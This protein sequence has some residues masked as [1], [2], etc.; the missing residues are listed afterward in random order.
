[1]TVAAATFAHATEMLS[2]WLAAMDTWWTDLPAP[3]A[4]ELGYFG[5]GYNHW[6]VQTNLKFM[7]AA[8][9]L[10]QQPQVE[11]AVRERARTRALA[12]LRWALAT[13][14][15]GERLCPDGQPWGH[16]WISPLGIERAMLGV[17]ALAD[18][19]TDSDRAALRRVLESEAHWCCHHYGKGEKHRGVMASKWQREGHNVPES[20]LWTGALLWRTAVLYPDHADAALWQEKAH[21]F[22]INSV[23]VEADATDRTEVA[24]KTVAERY[25]GPNFFP[26]FSLDHHGYLNVGYMVICSSQAS[27]LHFDLAVA[28]LPRPAS[29]DHHQADLWQVIRR[30]TFD[31]G[32]LARIG[33]DTRTR[34]TYCQEYLLPSL[35]YAAD[36]LGDG[37]ALTLAERQVQLIAQEFDANRE[38]SAWTGTF[39]GRRLGHLARLNPN[40]FVRLESD[41][42]AALAALLVYGPQVTPP[43]TAGAGPRFDPTGLWA[44]PE[45]GAVLHRG[46]H[47]LAS[48]AWYASGLAQGLCLPPDDG[49]LAEWAQNLSPVVRFAGDQAE[50][51]P[52]EATQR[53]VLHFTQDTF[54]GGFATCGALAEGVDAVLAEGARRT[55]Q[56]RSAI[57]FVALPDGRSTVVLHRVVG[58]GAGRGYLTRL[59]GLH[60]NVPNDLLNGQRRQLATAR[61]AVDLIAPVAE[62]QVLAL[63]SRWA[64]IDDR[65]GV[66]GVYGAEELVV[67]RHR[68]R[69][70]GKL[71]SLRVEELCFGHQEGPMTVDDG[72]ELLDIGAVVVCG[73]AGQTQAVVAEQEATS[74]PDLRVVRV[75][76][77]DG[78][79]YRV[80]ANLGADEA[81][82]AGQ[83]LAPWTAILLPA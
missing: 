23:S 83:T 30:M 12:A 25:V 39:Y 22:L 37:D 56:A 41:R 67:V 66:V 51:L 71:R 61:G 7:A 64:T 18:H 13:H 27:Y 54:A 49:H 34:Y 47:R 40:Y 45:H 69:L 42:A 57:A 8:A 59:S 60:L 44:E 72:Q 62:D 19:L 74:H 43:V 35:L 16:T 68:Q 11:P 2:A 26:N 82:H 4:A 31:D 70:G 50:A 46:P 36:R 17:T 58:T 3:S 32:R 73:D 10:S 1:M 38:T 15:S 75:R 52:G 80:A 65:L 5:T 9:A 78:R 29:L 6:G 33:G 28:G 21:D 81:A 20:N 48:F 63:G 53:R 76:G 77:Q 24:G 79:T 55:D 14:V